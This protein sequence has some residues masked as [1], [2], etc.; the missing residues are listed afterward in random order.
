MIQGIIRACRYK[1]I[2]ID[3]TEKILVRKE[4]KMPNIGIAYC[5]SL[6]LTL[7]EFL[8]YGIGEREAHFLKVKTIPKC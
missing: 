1:K 3:G 2:K 8:S 5:I 4:L 7:S 6:N